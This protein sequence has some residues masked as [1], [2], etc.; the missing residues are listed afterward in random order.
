MFGAP[1][2]SRMNLYNQPMGGGFF[3]G[4]MS[5]PQP[6]GGGFFGGGAPQ[7]FMG[8]PQGMFGA[9]APMMPGMFGG[10]RPQMGGMMPGMFGGSPQ[11]FMGSPQG[12]GMYGSLGGGMP[13]MSPMDQQRAASAAMKDFF[14]SQGK[15]GEGRVARSEADRPSPSPNTNFMGFLQRGIGTL[16][17]NQFMRAMPTMMRGIGGFF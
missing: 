17:P 8:S 2:G 15:A 4:G 12:M 5:Q 3:G 7:Q 10:G 9:P 6:M 13:T 11:Q 1:T 14:Q 16:M